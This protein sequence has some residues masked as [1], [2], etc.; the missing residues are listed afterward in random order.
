MIPLYLPESKSNESL[1][2]F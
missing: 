2:Y 1:R